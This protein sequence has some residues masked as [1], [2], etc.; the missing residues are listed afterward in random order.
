MANKVPNNRSR[1]HTAIALVAVLLAGCSWWPLGTVKVTF[2][3]AEEL[4]GVFVP[5]EA[6]KDKAQKKAKYE[7]KFY[8]VEG[9]DVDV[10][11]DQLELTV[12]PNTVEA[13]ID[14]LEKDGT[15]VGFKVIIPEPGKKDIKVT[16]GL[17]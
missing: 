12:E 9:K 6:N 1:V 5:D 16:I 10:D 7:A 17:K 13:T 15:V 8:F 4:K 14:P 2:E 11:V 3:F